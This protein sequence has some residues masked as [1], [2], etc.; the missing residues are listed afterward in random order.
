MF[1]ERKLG[2]KK[3]T[4]DAIARAPL[5][6]KASAPPP[7]VLDR[8]KIAYQPELDD[9]DTLGNCTAVGYANGARA[10]AAL[11]GITIN[12]PTSTVVTFYSDSTGYNP[13]D[14]STDQGGN[15]LAVLLYALQKGFP[16]G[17]QL[18]LAGNYGT[19]DP[20]DRFANAD[21]MARYGFVYS[22]LALAKADQNDDSEVW[23]T[24][25]PASAGDPTPG[26]WGDHCAL[27]WDYTGL[28]DTDIV[29]VATW[30]F[31]KRATWRWVKSR[32]EEAHSVSWRN[33]AWQQHAPTPGIVIPKSKRVMTIPK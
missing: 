14:P 4:A 3:H 9:N 7:A 33:L 30:G 26:S 15:E 25:T 19:M 22:G 28:E 23:D 27:L 16:A 10:V 13:A 1:I 11:A 32:Q 31:K 6:A 24:D 5:Y 17:D 20:T 29:T 18:M 21:A 8:S 12:I 2:R